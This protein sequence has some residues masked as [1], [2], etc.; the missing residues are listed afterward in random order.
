MAQT[1]TSL[2]RDGQREKLNRNGIYVH[3]VGPNHGTATLP[4]LSAAPTSAATQA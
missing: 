2:G 1:I 4:L 3:E